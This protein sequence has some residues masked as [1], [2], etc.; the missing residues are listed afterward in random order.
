MKIVTGQTMAEIDR[1]A[2]QERG[3]PSLS[4]MESAGRATAEHFHQLC[5]DLST[6]VLVLC[7][8]GNN[9]GD[10]L[11]ATRYLLGR[12]YRPRVI[13]TH[14]PEELSQDS[15]SNFE[16]FR[17]LPFARWSVWGM[18]PANHWI[19]DNPVVIDT[20]L[21][22][23]AQG[24]P[25]SPYKEV[26]EAVNRHARWALGVDISS[27]IDSETGCAAGNAVG[28]RSTITFGLPMVG[29]FRGDG[30]DYTGTLSIADIGF[31]QDVICNADGEAD[32]IT[33]IW[34]RNHLPRYPRSVHKSD[35]GRVLI[36]AGSAAMLGAA[37]LCALSAV[38]AGA[39]LTTL[40]IPK[41]LNAGVKGTIPE[42]MTL[43]LEET[44]RGEI[45]IDALDTLLESSRSSD[46]LGIG[47][48]IGRSDETGNLVRSLVEKVELPMVVDADGLFLLSDDVG[49][50]IL[51]ERSFPTVLTPHAGEF[52]RLSGAISMEDLEENSWSASS[53][54]SETLKSTVLLKGPATVIASPESPLL[55]NRSGH[56]AMAQG[57]MGDVL[58]GVITTFLGEGLG[59][60]EAA[61]LGAF[62][63]GR[64]GE[65]AYRNQGARTVM[66]GEVIESL[67]NVF[68]GLS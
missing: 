51:R 63:H 60:N 47:P 50:E 48:G 49:R 33:E 65:W 46:A 15:Q 66:A 35:R 20:L 43:P 8:K 6:R 18:E 28:C 40:A 54:L 7:G 4:L 34:A 12:G 30:I 68:R 16:R 24:E 37:I 17:E 23:G 14:P 45:S 19:A 41:S 2:I 64:A 1:I 62:V 36:I 31:P 59:P 42:V 57:G 61:G 25:R 13:L 29:H 52:V 27:G 58:T 26:I 10:G 5:G 39:G 22:T 56:P 67:P 3:V 44:D 9:G 53:R 11:V 32:L 38:K 55:I 21:G